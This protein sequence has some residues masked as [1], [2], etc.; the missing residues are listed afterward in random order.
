MAPEHKTQNSLR[1]FP[2][3]SDINSWGNE[4]ILC[5]P[6]FQTHRQP[7]GNPK[8]ISAEMTKDVCQSQG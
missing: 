8:A 2:E 5:P 6:G 1:I 3:G 4:T 7:H